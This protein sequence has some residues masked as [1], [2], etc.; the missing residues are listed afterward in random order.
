MFSTSHIQPHR[1]SR[2]FALSAWSLEVHQVGCSCISCRYRSGRVCRA[3]TISS[4]DL[5]PSPSE[6]RSRV[7]PIHV[8][9]CGEF[10]IL[11][12]RE[13]VWKITAQVPPRLQLPFPRIASSEHHPAVLLLPTTLVIINHS[14]PPPHATTGSVR[15]T[16]KRQ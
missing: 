10:N 6:L 14:S 15:S 13:R 3:G 2:C 12:V 4:P 9:C 8:V 5:L 7:I 16:Q 11:I 1:S